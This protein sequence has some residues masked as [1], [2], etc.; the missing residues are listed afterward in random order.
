M[1]YYFK[2]KK[3]EI[4]LGLNGD[5]NT[6]KNTNIVNGFNNITKSENY[7]FGL[8]ASKQ[9]DKKYDNSISANATYTTSNSSIQSNI[10]THYWTFNVHPDLDFYLP[11]KFQ[12]HSD[13]DFIYRQKTSTFDNDNNVI[14]WNLW[15]GKKLLKNDA[16]LVKVSGNDL[17]NQNIGFNR[18]VNTNF[19]SQNT[20]TTIQRYFMLSVV[21][22]FNKNGPKQN[23]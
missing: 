20:Y 19:I 12:I 10:N 21:W 7:S 18:T 11:L 4:R 8:Y 2:L 22:N 16:L 14:L 6:N 13:C 15:V 9:K 5:I 1:N 17:L 3:P 23:N